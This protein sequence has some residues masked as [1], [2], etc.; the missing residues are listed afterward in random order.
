MIHRSKL[1]IAVLDLLLCF[2]MTGC[3]GANPLVISKKPPYPGPWCGPHQRVQIGMRVVGHVAFGEKKWKYFLVDDAGKE[4]DPEKLAD[5]VW[6]YLER[7]GDAKKI[8][9]AFSRDGYYP[10]MIV[11]SIKPVVVILETYPAK[12][13]GTSADRYYWVAQIH[14]MG[15]PIYQEGLQW[16][17]PDLK[18]RP[19]N[20]AF[21]DA[22]V[23]EIS[24]KNGKLKVIR[25][26]D[27]CVS[28]RE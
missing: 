5:Q 6:S 11:V 15:D 27:K 24:L 2:S 9:E 19:T 22:G 10:R 25:E 16:F 23:A 12:Q 8:K 20:L 14:A 7:T 13:L 28:T 17:S 18:Q 26:G 3:G 1:C 4:Y 21:S